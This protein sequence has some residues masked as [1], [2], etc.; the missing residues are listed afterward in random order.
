MFRSLENLQ[1]GTPSTSGTQSNMGMLMSL[2]YL[3]TDMH[4]LKLLNYLL[5]LSIYFTLC[6]CDV[7]SWKQSSFIKFD[8]I[9]L[10]EKVHDYFHVV[11]S[12]KEHMCIAQHI[13]NKGEMLVGF[14]Y[15]VNL[16]LNCSLWLSIVFVTISIS[17]N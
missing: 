3:D 10:K 6:K 8:K 5:V 7:K 4:S 17:F 13:I 15:Q 16:L 9:Y 2:F 12:L 14:V 1:Q 11:S